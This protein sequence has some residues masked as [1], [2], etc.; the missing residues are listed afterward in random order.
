MAAETQD[1]KLT[2]AE[3]V[4][5]VSLL[6]AAG[7]ETTVNLLGNGLRALWQHRPCL[8]AL[9][10]LTLLPAAV[11]EML[12]FDSS[13]QLTG[14]RALEITFQGHDIKEGDNVITLLGAANH[15]GETFPSRSARL[16]RKAQSP[17][18]RGRHSLLL[19][20]PAQSHRGGGS[21]PGPFRAL[22]QARVDPSVLEAPEQKPTITLRGLGALPARWA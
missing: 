2:G 16:D 12:R 13:V 17:L 10:D 14:R 21:A 22:A 9:R 19:S 5:N 8:D 4:A 20:R 6:F 3:L 18:L 1:G 15:D 7:H 11:E